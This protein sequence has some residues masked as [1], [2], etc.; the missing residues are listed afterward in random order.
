MPIELVDATLR[1]LDAAMTDA[2]ELAAQLDAELADNWEGFP[3]VL[4][5]LR[6]ELKRDP[7][8]RWATTL[9]M[10]REPRTLV[11]MGGYKGPPR[12]GVV[13]IG[14]AIAPAFQ[15]RGFA[16]EA[17]RALVARAFADAA[18]KAVDAH[19]LGEDNASTRVLRKVGMQHIG[20]TVDTEHGTIWHWRITR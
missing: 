6:A 16:T 5:L 7:S 17:A 2:Q 19:T 3:E 13:E 1:L 11:G 8:T 4:P 18:V 9:F 15:Q 20:E 10:L 12:D 14:Y